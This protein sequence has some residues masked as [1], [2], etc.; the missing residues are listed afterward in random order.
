MFGKHLAHLAL[1]CTLALIGTARMQAQMSPEHSQAFQRAQQQQAHLAQQQAQQMQAQQAQQMLQQPWQTYQQWYAQQQMRLKPPQ[2]PIQNNSLS[3][4][5]PPIQAVPS[6]PMFGTPGIPNAGNW[7]TP[8]PGPRPTPTWNT[9]TTQPATLQPAVTQPTALRPNVTQPASLQPA[10]LQPTVT[11]PAA[12]QPQTASSNSPA[13]S[14]GTSSWQPASQPASGS[15]SKPVQSESADQASPQKHAGAAEQKTAANFTS[16]PLQS[17]L[18]RSQSSPTANPNH[19]AGPSGDPQKEPAKT[20]AAPAGPT[21]P[22]QPQS[23]LKR[24]PMSQDDPPTQKLTASDLPP[25][26][27]VPV[28]GQRFSEI[29]TLLVRISGPEEGL[30]DQ[31]IAFSVEVM[32]KGTQTTDM[33]RSLIVHTGSPSIG[34]NGLP[35]GA[36]MNFVFNLPPRRF[37][38]RPVPNSDLAYWE[39]HQLP[40]GS[41]QPNETRILTFFMTPRRAKAVQVSVY[42]GVWQIGQLRGQRSALTPVSNVAVA[43]VQVKYDPRE[44]FMPQPPSVRPSVGL[45][46]S[47]AEVPEVSFQEPLTAAIDSNM[48]RLHTARVIDRINFLNDRKT[49]FFMTA[50]IGARPDLAGLPFALGDDSRMKKDDGR[51]FV[52]AL[53]KIRERQR[54]LEDVPIS[55]ADSRFMH[56]YQTRP[57]TTDFDARASVAA[58]MQVLGPESA[59]D[60][61]GLA[62]HL[63]G[64]PHVAATQALARLAIFSEEPEIRWQAVRALK[65]RRDRDYSDILVSG[66]QYP[67]PA[68][69]ERS[70]DAIVKLGRTDLIPQ[71]IDVLGE[72]DPRAPQTREF[73]GKHT[74]VVREVVRLNHLQNCLLCHA[75]ASPDPR[76]TLQ[77]KVQFDKLTGQV[78]LPSQSLT[79]H[80]SE[81]NA[82]TLVRFDVTY[83]RQDFSMK[84]PVANAAPWPN[85]QRYDFLVRAREVSAQEAAALA[86]LL[87]SGESP[88][89]RAALSALRQ[90]TGHDAEPTAAAWREKVG[91]CPLAFH[92]AW[93]F[94][95]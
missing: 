1:A 26:A 38:S 43:R 84:L 48:A 86:K 60:R 70:S 13:V 5:Q 22:Q 89:H 15:L 20:A 53:E 3:Q 91:I 4:T 62:L 77:E 57:R 52:A 64:E 92:Q 93:P 51:Q 18:K 10:I 27:K 39:G 32:N 75:P 19:S 47:L 55:A 79:A 44:T 28:A 34:A 35:E 24:Q 17:L 25:Q 46:R 31:P 2:P 40:V 23:L 58:L 61:H 68:V 42:E 73:A 63:G 59:S 95:G 85:M 30:V 50:L 11:Q 72:P 8:P 82:D 76:M 29:G 65:M 21:A 37:D 71:L 7:P 6:T 12:W 16:Q 83:L 49:D 33:N 54:L 56:A 94:N 14:N 66:L 90:L 67:W 74:T 41:I 45:P 80:Y 36:S 81:S 78:P 87:Q 69:A 9:S 88:Y